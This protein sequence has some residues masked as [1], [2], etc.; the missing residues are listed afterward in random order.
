MSG[1]NEK[2]VDIT[3]YEG[4]YQVS[5]SGDVV[6]LNFHH[7]GK[8]RV[9]KPSVLKNG[10]L[11][12]NL[13]KNGVKKTYT[14]HQLVAKAFIPNPDKLTCVNHKNEIKSDNRVENLEW[15]DSKYNVNYGTR[16]LRI[17]EKHSKPVIQLTKEGDF[18]RNWPSMSEVERE[19]K[20]YQ[21]SI[22]KCCTEKRKSACGFRWM[23]LEDYEKLINP[24]E[25]IEE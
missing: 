9:L 2:W 22:S 4:M 18:V 21:S 14:I 7:T 20:I 17:G 10:Y 12:V 5:R 11:C 23:Y 19:L 1:D 13:Y 15:C 24:Y 8:K 3:G 16:N 25:K 6:S